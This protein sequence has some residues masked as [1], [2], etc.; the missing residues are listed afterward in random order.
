MKETIPKPNCI[1]IPV[2]NAIKLSEH[3][4]STIRI[5]FVINGAA[6][7]IGNS[8]ILLHQVVE[9]ENFFCKGMIMFYCSKPFSASSKN[10]AQ[11]IVRMSIAA[12]IT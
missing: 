5:Q 9:H 12:V 8:S 3:K 6:K 10:H 1:K 7:Y 4:A 11:G 2:L